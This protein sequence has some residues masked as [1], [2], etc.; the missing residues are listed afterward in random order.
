MF[1]LSGERPDFYDFSVGA[2]VNLWRHW[3]IGFANTIVPLNRDGF[4]ADVVPFVGVEA[5]LGRPG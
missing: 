1:G 4:R 3:L 2:R 5:V